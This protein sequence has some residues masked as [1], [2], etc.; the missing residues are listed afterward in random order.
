MVEE[1]LKELGLELP[2]IPSPVAA[3]VPGVC[4]D[5]I[6]YTSGQLPSAEGVVRTGRLGA[7]MSVEDGYE[8]ARICALNCLAVVKNL[9]GS[10][11]RVERVLKVTGFVNSTPEFESQPKVVNGASELLQ[12][13]FGDNG[14]HSR[15]AVGV[16]SLPLG[17]C[18]EV[19]I[20]VKLKQGE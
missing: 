8:A 6:I 5:G 10:L 12:Q 18:C 13:V 9:A 4:S 11:D 16:G 20:I 7:D 19:E 14:V 3:Y 1:R 2:Q 15:S 17:A